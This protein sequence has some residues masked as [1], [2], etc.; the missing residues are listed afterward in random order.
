[1]SVERER[2]PCATCVCRPGPHLS[3]ISRKSVLDLFE[4]YLRNDETWS[5]HESPTPPSAP[6]VAF[7]RLK[8]GRGTSA[9]QHNIEV[10]H[11]RSARPD[12]ERL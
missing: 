1:M 5:C 12:R 9:A 4:Q 11:G 2:S 8:R 3:A 7:L 6:C 10:Q